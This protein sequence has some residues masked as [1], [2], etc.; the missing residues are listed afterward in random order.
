MVRLRRTA[1]IVDPGVEAWLAAQQ[2]PSGAVLAEMERVGAQRGFPIVGPLVGRLLETTARMVGARSVFEM[3]SGFGYSTQWYARAVGE[4]GRVVHTDG[5]A[6]LSG[7]ARGWLAKTGVEDR[8]DFRVGN[9]LD[10]L[11]EDAAYDVVFI[12]VDKHQYPDAWRIARDH[13]RRGG[14]VV[15]DNTLWSGKVCDERVRDRDTEGVRGYVQAAMSDPD[16]LTTIVPIRDGVAV[17]LR[18]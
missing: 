2:G 12:D 1:V 18:L 10:L 4:G 17:S 16:F 11:E 14:L 7:E 3:G 9:A 8:V 6:E 13:V 15:T 5:D